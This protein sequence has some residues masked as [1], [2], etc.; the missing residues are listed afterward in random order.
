MGLF[1]YFQTPV[2]TEDTDNTVYGYELTNLRIRRPWCLD[3]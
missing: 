2:L 1:G 3:I